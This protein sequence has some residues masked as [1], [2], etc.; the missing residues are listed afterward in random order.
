VYYP[1]RS[2]VLIE[3][4]SIAIEDLVD[5]EVPINGIEICTSMQTIATL[6]LI[7]QPS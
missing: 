7:Y 3:L 2:E 1:D 5:C 6:K 4:G